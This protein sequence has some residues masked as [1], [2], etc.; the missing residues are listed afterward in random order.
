MEDESEI[1]RALEEASSLRFGDALRKFFIT[2][3]IHVKPSNPYKL[4]NSYKEQLA[5]DW[6]RNMNKEKAINKLL[7]WLKNNLSSYE[8]M[9]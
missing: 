3:I 8:F 4:W 5:A 2:I 9:N 7:I 6:L 1:D